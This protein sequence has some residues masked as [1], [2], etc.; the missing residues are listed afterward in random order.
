MSLLLAI[1]L[2]CP[3]GMPLDGPIVRDFAPVGAYGGHWGVDVAAEVGS[4][5]HPIAPGRVSFTGEVAGRSSV[6]I[7][8]GGGVRSSYSYLSGVAVR[9]GESVTRATVLGWS[10]VDQ[11][12]GAVHVSVR[13]NSEYVAPTLGVCR[14]VPAPGLRLGPARP[15]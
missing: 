3:F 14:L 4:I 12:I 15:V 13:I 7:D 1:S 11:G 9:R 5:V 6:T 10:G 2:V 8:H